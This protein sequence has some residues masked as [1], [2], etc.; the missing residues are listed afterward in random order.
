MLSKLLIISSLRDNS[1]LFAHQEDILRV[2]EANS[3]KQ[4]YDILRSGYAYS[5]VRSFGELSRSKD[6]QSYAQI[7]DKTSSLSICNVCSSRSS[8]GS[9][10]GLVLGMV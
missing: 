3:H 8:C 6:F 10:C 4:L 2:P 1:K 9:S 5:V 7:V